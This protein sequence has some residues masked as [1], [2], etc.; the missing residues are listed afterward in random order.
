MTQE[1]LPY[2]DVRKMF[3]WKDN[4]TIRHYVTQGKLVRV[5]VNESRKG[6]RITR[7]SAEAMMNEVLETAEAMKQFGISK[8]KLKAWREARKRKPLPVLDPVID[9]RYEEPVLPVLVPPVESP[10]PPVEAKRQTKTRE[11]LDLDFAKAYLAGEATDSCGNTIHGNVKNISGNHVI[12]TAESQPRLTE[13]AS[14]TAHM[15]LTMQ[16]EGTHAMDVPRPLENGDWNELWHPGEKGRRA[17]MY[18]KCG[19]RQLSEQERKRQADTRCISAAFDE[20][21]GTRYSR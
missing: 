8:G 12:L 7:A 2:R 16:E 21:L 6:L 9:P 15:E 14:T 18:A 3:G 1:L 10:D 4:S 20:P 17:A 5:R 19:V 11:Q 13:R